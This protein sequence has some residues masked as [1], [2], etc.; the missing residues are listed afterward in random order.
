MTED[1]I[2]PLRI[3]P[4]AHGGVCVARWEGRV[5]FVAGTL[6]GELAMVEVTR[7]QTRQWHG[8][9]A[10]ILEPSP[11]RR[12]HVWPLAEQTGVGGADL[13][14][15]ALPAQRDW[16]AA[17]IAGQLRRL[18]HLERTVQVAP[19]PGDDGRGGLAW[20][21]RV[22]FEADPDGRLAMHAAAE[23]RLVP[24]DSMPL[25]HEAIAAL[26]PWRQAYEPGQRVRV[27]HSAGA[28]PDG[29]DASA[30]VV[31][32]RAD[33]PF[34]VEHLGLPGVPD[35]SYRLPALGF[36]QV[37]RAAPAVL[38]A[39]VLEA[40]ALA[41]GE[42]V[43]DLYSGSGLFV[44]PLADAVG[45]RGRVWA[46]EADQASAAAAAANS[47]GRPA[48]RVV[49]GDVAETLGGFTAPLGELGQKARP[50]RPEAGRRAKPAAP[51]PLP[52]RADAIILDPPR[53]GVSRRVL[54]ACCARAPRRIVYVACDIAA[55][56]RDLA[57]LAEAGYQLAELRAFD[58]FP[59]THHTECVALCVRS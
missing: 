2:G 17:V 33:P 42:T 47:L 32:E 31:A 6:P 15:V 51:K 20:R 26:A 22:D 37:H 24:V 55:L 57:L 40:A 34:V 48:A 58:L 18:A 39:A 16:K 29:S 59:H 36:W 5:V 49:C 12:L 11:D 13:G 23:H 41:A 54:A 50:P 56:A 21:T 10:E 4:P 38:A 35:C 27:V 19:A 14:H 25:A 28:S 44:L 9:A 3:G 1:R 45:P 30:L 43:F 53:T 52:R 46:V 8:R 7:R